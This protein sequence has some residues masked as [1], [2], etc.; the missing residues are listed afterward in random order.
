MPK[1]SP[2]ITARPNG[3]F[4]S[5]PSELP[6]AIGITPRIMARAVIRTGRSRV[7]ADSMAAA[8]ALKPSSER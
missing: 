1:T 4:C 8:A 6:M 5:P 3:A 7:V 2:P